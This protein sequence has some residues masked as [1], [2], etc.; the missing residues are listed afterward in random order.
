MKINLLPQRRD[1]SLR[2]LKYGDVLTIN[3]TKYGFTQL[4][5]GE[6]LP[7]SATDCPWLIGDITRTDGELE[8]TLILPHG[9]NPSPAVAFPEPITVTE[10]GEVPLPFD[11]EP[12]LTEEMSA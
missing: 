11:A 4:G 10:D 9:P 12:E 3:G 6:T 5:E 8:L 1:D 7:A 2:V